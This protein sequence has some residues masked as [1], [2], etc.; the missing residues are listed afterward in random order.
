MKEDVFVKLYLKRPKDRKNCSFKTW[1]YTIARNMALDYLRKTK[2]EALLSADVSEDSHRQEDLLEEKYIAEETKRALE[3]ALK[4]INPDYAAALRLTFYE[5]FSSEETAH[6]LKKSV[7]STYD[8]IYR[9]KKS[10]KEQLIKDGFT[11]EIR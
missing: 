9:A 10:L 6:I 4:S 1:L 2:R 3:K 11:Y 7:K 8:L 5:G